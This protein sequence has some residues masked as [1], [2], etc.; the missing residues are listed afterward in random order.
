MSGER[1]FT[2]AQ[3][4][5]DYVHREMLYGHFERQIPLP[6]GMDTNKL[7]AEYRNGVLEMSAPLSAAALP[8]RIE[9]KGGESQTKQIGVGASAS[10]RQ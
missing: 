5:A 2:Q 8:R 9:I 3:N 7:D 6:D 1:R 10:G 4:Q